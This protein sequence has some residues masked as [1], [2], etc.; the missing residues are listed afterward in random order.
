MVF[1]QTASAADFIR[2]AF[3]V[4]GIASVLFSWV[5]VIC[6]ATWVGD[7]N[8]SSTGITGR[9][10]KSGAAL[11]CGS[12]HSPNKTLVVSISGL[13]SLTVG[14]SSTYTVTVSGGAASTNIGVD[15][16]ASDAG[17][18][19][20]SATNLKV[21]SDEITHTTAIDPLNTT[22]ASG[23][24]SYSFTYTMPAGAPAGSIHTLYA[25]ARVGLEWNNANQNA[26]NTGTNNFSI[27]AKQ[28]QTITAF[29]NGLS[30]PPATTFGASGPLAISGGLGTG[31]VTYS[32]SN[33]SVCTVSNVTDTLSAVGVGSCTK[34][35]S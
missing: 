15:I 7:A 33:T 6:S 32:S 17:S 26:T 35:C 31:A 23:T 5:A 1:A 21:L 28:N 3:S 12:C 18:L 29:F 10:L 27:T 30:A 4:R 8:S 24:G 25:A 34:H 22:N 19:S 14:T 11:G 20:E 16:A 2:R 9:T 13:S